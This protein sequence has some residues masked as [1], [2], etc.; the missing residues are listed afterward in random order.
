MEINDT[1]SYLEVNLQQYY[2]EK[3]CHKIV[4]D[5]S[6]KG[7]KNKVIN[8]MN[9]RLK[10]HLSDVAIKANDTVS[11]QQKDENLLISVNCPISFE[12]KD[13]Q[14]NRKALYILLRL[15]KSENGKNLVTQKF[16]WEKVSDKLENYFYEV[17]GNEKYT[18]RNSL[19]KV[20][21]KISILGN[22]ENYVLHYN[23]PENNEFQFIYYSGFLNK[24]TG[25]I[26]HTGCI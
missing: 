15:F 13:T 23:D 19:Q 7:V 3:W 16:S 21:W 1:W 26:P 5:K 8:T 18:Y 9:T 12:I 22:K 2:N 11:V 20:G 10:N 6:L 14:N 17:C 25:M 24:K 4:V